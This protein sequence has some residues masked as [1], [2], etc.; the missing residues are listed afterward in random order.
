MS[1]VYTFDDVSD[2][3]VTVCD[4]ICTNLVREFN[5][6]FQLKL[7]FGGNALNYGVQPKK[8]LDKIFLTDDVVNLV[9]IAYFDAINDGTF[10]SDEQLVKKYFSRTNNVRELFQNFLDAFGPV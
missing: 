3:T 5:K 4:E 6:L 9:M 7:V 10:L 8:S 1:I 2:C